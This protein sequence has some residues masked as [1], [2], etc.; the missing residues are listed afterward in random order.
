LGLPAIP[1]GVVEFSDRL[2][3][4]DGARGCREFL[5]TALT[6]LTENEELQKYDGQDYTA[7]SMLSL[8]L[9]AKLA[10]MNI[11]ET[12]DFLS[13]N[14]SRMKQIGLETVPTK[15]A[16]TKFRQR[17]GT[18]FNRILGL[19]IAYIYPRLHEL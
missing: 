17:M 19:L 18:D 12:L 6:W 16:V 1:A 4:R 15:G 5:N 11:E 8:F 7:A 9:F 10:R 3:K 13:S 14:K 2:R